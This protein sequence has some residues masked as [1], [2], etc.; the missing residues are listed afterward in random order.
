MSKLTLKKMA[1][2]DFE[3]AVR[4]YARLAV[5]LYSEIAVTLVGDAAGANVRNEIRVKSF[6]DKLKR[7]LGLRLAKLKRSKH[8]KLHMVSST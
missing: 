5:E 4:K 8:T 7:L 2:P 6:L 1:T 3:N